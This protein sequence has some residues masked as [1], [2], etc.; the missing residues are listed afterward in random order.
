MNQILNNVLKECKLLFDQSFNVPLER[1]EIYGEVKTD[2]NLIRDMFELIPG[3]LFKNPGIRWCDPC[4]GSGEFMIFLFKVL[5]KT[6]QIQD[7][8]ERRRHI[9]RN[10]LWMIE[11]NE[12]H[13]PTLEVFFGKESNII[14]GSY[15][16]INYLDVDVVIGNP[17]FNIDGELA[18]W[19]KFVIHSLFTMLKKSR[20]GYLLFIT[21]SIWM[22]R[23]YPLFPIMLNRTIYKI[24]S[25]NSSETN[26]IFHGKA[27]TPTCYFLMNKRKK[28]KFP[29]HKPIQ[30]YDDITKKFLPFKYISNNGLLTSLP[31]CGVSI[32]NKIHKYNFCAPLSVN[33]TN[34]RPG[35]KNLSISNIQNLEYPYPNVTTCLLKKNQPI[36][37]INYSN[38]KC[39]WFGVSKLIFAHK[40]YGFPYFDKEGK[41]GIS[42][43]DNYVIHDYSE[44]H[45]SKICD[46]FYTDLGLYILEMTRYRMRYLEKYIFNLIPDI[47]TKIET[48]TNDSINSL[49]E[50]N[51]LER[52]YIN[53][54]HKKHYLKTICP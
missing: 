16:N 22:K 45:L 52:N 51:E 43:R 28:H 19:S 1:K 53:T 32:L 47:I 25:L 11:I 41:F 12:Y 7:I 40:M 50:L 38:I 8:E 2:F 5:D 54:F 31:L 42:N 20:Y 21:P 39:E 26:Q 13:I 14:H 29:R 46:F 18:I 49:F 6:I 48:V 35:Y 4:C 24:R 17:P 15:L 37:K 33:K 3:H 9:K 34:M 23:D 10:M 30:L 36:L 27:Q 44:R